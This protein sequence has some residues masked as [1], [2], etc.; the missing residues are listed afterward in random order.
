MQYLNGLEASAHTTDDAM[1]ACLREWAYSESDRRNVMP[2]GMSSVKSDTFGLTHTRD[3][4]RASINTDTAEFKYFARLQAEWL[5]GKLRD[6]DS[7]L[8]EFLCAPMAA[9]LQRKSLRSG[10]CSADSRAPAS[11]RWFSGG[12]GMRFA[13][14]RRA[15]N[16]ARWL[17]SQIRY[18]LYV[19]IIL[20]FNDEYL[21]RQPH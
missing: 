4:E 10:R 14:A 8:Q 18:G 20:F 21:H 9:R 7:P 5:R 6:M 15:S 3:A 1:L 12:S 2:E 13:V 19:C 17:L 11:C 16:C